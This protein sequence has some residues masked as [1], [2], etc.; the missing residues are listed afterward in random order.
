[1][2]DSVRQADGVLWDGYPRNK[3]KLPRQGIGDTETKSDLLL[4]WLQQQGSAGTG[5]TSGSL[6]S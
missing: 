6:Q 3:L 2:A 1:V 5:T 4:R